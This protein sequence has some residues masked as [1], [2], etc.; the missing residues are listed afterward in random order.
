MTLVAV[1]AQVVSLQGIRLPVKSGWNK[2]LP[3]GC[4]PVH[5]AR[6][7]SRPPAFRTPSERLPDMKGALNTLFRTACVGLIVL[8]GYAFFERN[9]LWQQEKQARMLRLQDAYDA[10]NNEQRAVSLSERGNLNA[11][12]QVGEL[13]TVLG[14]KEAEVVAKEDDLIFL[15]SSKPL[16]LNDHEKAEVEHW[17]EHSAE[18]KRSGVA[19]QAPALPS[20]HVA[21]LPAPTP[22]RFTGTALSTGQLPSLDP[23]TN[24]PD[25]P[26]PRAL[27][28]GRVVG[29]TD[30]GVLVGCATP[31]ERNAIPGSPRLA[32]VGTSLAQGIVL[33]IGDPHEKIMADGDLLT[34]VTG[35]QVDTY[36]YEA[37]GA[38][39]TARGYRYVSGN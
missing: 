4:S 18:F 6:P 12:A 31:A 20:I 10:F 32:L 38:I 34:Y 25:A 16:P 15:Y 28:C 30:H 23:R 36:Q 17:A 26:G 3:S 11:R 37:G 39:R 13:K 19:S 24:N 33:L 14:Q 35:E 9:S 5:H 7:E 2:I 22:F 1:P 8:L 29:K 27:I 21:V